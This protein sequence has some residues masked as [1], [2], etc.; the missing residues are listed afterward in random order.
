[1]IYAHS[2]NYFFTC[3]CSL[4]QG[5]SFLDAMT[6]LWNKRGWQSGELHKDFRNECYKWLTLLLGTVRLS[7]PNVSILLKRFFA[8]RRNSIVSD[9]EFRQQMIQQVLEETRKN[10]P[11]LIIQMYDND[12]ASQQVGINDI[13]PL[14]FTMNDLQNLIKEKSLLNEGLVP[15]NEEITKLQ[16]INEEQ[17]KKYQQLQEANAQLEEK[18]KQLQQEATLL[19]TKNVK[20]EATNTHLQEATTQ[21]EEKNKQLQQEATLLETKNVKLEAINTHLQEATTQLEEKNKQMQQEATL[22]ETKNVKLEAT[23]THLQEATTQLEEKNKQMQQEATLLE[24]KNVKLEATNTH[25]QEATTQ[26][27]EK[28]KQLQQEAT[29]LETKNVQLEATNVQLQQEK[30]WLSES[31]D[32]VSSGYEELS[33]VYEK[34]KERSS[35]LV[36]KLNEMET[37]FNTL[38]KNHQQLQDAKETITNEHRQLQ[39]RYHELHKTNNEVTI[40]YKQEEKKCQQLQDAQEAMTSKHSQLEKEHQLVKKKHEEVIQQKQREYQLLQNTHDELI[41]SYQQKEQK[42]VQ[43]HQTQQ[44]LEDILKAK[45]DEVSSLLG[46]ITATEQSWKVNY[47]EVTLT[48]QELGRGGWGVV[49]I[50]EFRGQKVAVKQ[51]HDSIVSDHF[52]QLLNREINTM[53]QLRHPN[54]LQFIGAVLDHPSG[55]PMIIT[56][57][58]DISLRGAYEKKQLS[59]VPVSI[60]LS[61]MRDVAVGLNYLHCLPDPIIHRDVSSANVL[62]ESK[63]PGKWKTKISDFG[64]AKFARSAVTTAAGAAVYS[65]PEALQSVAFIHKKKQTTKMD[66]FSYGVLFLE[67]MSCQFP[68]SV[69]VFQNIFEQLK[70]SSPSIHQLILQCISEDPEHRPT[71]KQVIQQ[72]DSIK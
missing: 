19:E 6:E 30:R 68:G 52:L 39:K 3:I 12:T 67:V 38:Q 36:T 57:I 32:N 62:L 56:E 17:Q 29:L 64:S 51:I 66:V 1:M 16:E 59:P 61:I 63:G 53:A 60:C 43:L 48:K 71:M 42:I 2:N 7:N 25:L 46:R 44:Q 40:A 23:N 70:T 41:T 18:N 4:A 37:R 20:L 26:L 47:K 55:N 11:N 33:D 58:M 13:A 22:L 5:I 14:H 49:W 50:G 15:L 45:Q 8:Q 69:D 10:F 28:N 24:T 65:A 34:Q 72:F 35:T 9:S 31:F 21:L 54:L 27:E